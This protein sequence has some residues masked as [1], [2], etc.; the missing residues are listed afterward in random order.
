MARI[1]QRR[2]A[3]GETELIG[4]RGGRGGADEGERKEKRCRPKAEGKASPLVGVYNVT[5]A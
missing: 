3:A 4:R 2:K 5:S 1:D